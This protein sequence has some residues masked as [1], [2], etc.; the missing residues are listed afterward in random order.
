MVDPVGP[1]TMISKSNRLFSDPLLFHECLSMMHFCFKR[2]SGRLVKS[3]QRWLKFTVLLC[4]AAWKPA[5]LQADANNGVGGPSQISDAFTFVRVCYD[6]VGGYNEAWYQYEGRVW[7]RWETD[8]PRAE[9]NLIFR[10]NELTSMKIDPEPIVLRLTDDRLL[11]HPLIFMSDVGWQKLSKQERAGLERYLKRGGFLWVDDFWGKAE[12]DSFMQNI[13][14]LRPNWKV[15]PIPP[16][17][18]IFSIVYPVKKCPQI[19]ARIFYLQTGMPWD[20]P[21]AH[22]SP[23]GGVAGVNQVRFMGLFDERDRLMAVATHN[24]D[25]ADGWERE[26]ESKEFFQRFS[27]QS[28][29]ITI[30]ILVY[31]LTH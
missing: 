11:D 29:A 10:L 8:Y 14:T 25:I 21:F 7:Q 5:H 27:I 31:A 18:P 6:S 22:R 30:N 12:W 2:F 26:G 15:R 20:P 19:P 9:K 16:D 3:H 23:T 4:L 17:H 24:T 28:Y 13:G 1:V